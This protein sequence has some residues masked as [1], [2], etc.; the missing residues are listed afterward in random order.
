MET[1]ILR[2]KRKRGQDPLEALHVQ[3]RRRRL[4][5][6]VFALGGTL[7]AGQLSDAR[8]VQALQADLLQRTT[9]TAAHPPALSVP[10][11]LQQPA[12][13][14]PVQRFRLASAAAQPSTS[15]YGIP[16]VVSASKP[17][18]ASVRA[19]ELIE[20]DCGG[21][22]S[23]DSLVPLVQGALAL[24]PPDYVYDFYYHTRQTHPH[25]SLAAWG[26]V[27]C[28]DDE[29]GLFDFAGDSSGSERGDELDEDS[30]AEDHY[31]NEYPDDESDGDGDLLSDMDDDTLM[32]DEARMHDYDDYNNW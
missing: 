20:E 32:R 5:P 21:E 30:N 3:Q 16:C 28:D 9:Q 13:A 2:V 15:A 17:A 25:G 11:E 23:V 1:T 4:A 14:Q 6:Q 26:A 19:V 8:A 31:A 10:A 12:A 7:T 29:D 18:S 27:V 22:H 24:E